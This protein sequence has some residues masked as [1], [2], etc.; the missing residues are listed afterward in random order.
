MFHTQVIGN[1]IPEIWTL[2]LQERRLPDLLLQKTVL[3]V[4]QQV[5]EGVMGFYDGVAGT[6]TLASAYDLASYGYAGYSDREQQGNECFS[7]C[8]HKGFY[9][10]QKDS[11]IKGVILIRCPLCFIPE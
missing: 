10:I 9:G 6:T 5:M 11:R 7:C 4:K 8:L 3:T 1:K 2:F